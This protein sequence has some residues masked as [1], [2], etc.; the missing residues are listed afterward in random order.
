[1]QQDSLPRG[2]MLVMYCRSPEDQLRPYRNLEA[3]RATIKPP[4]SSSGAS[5]HHH[6]VL[7]HPADPQDCTAMVQ[8]NSKDYTKDSS[9]RGM[10]R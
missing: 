8:E 10:P 6:H 2:I 3:K 1:M 4:C 5:P 9:G 7:N